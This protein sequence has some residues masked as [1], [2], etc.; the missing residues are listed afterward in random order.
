MTPELGE[1]LAWIEDL[2]AAGRA[3]S[4]GLVGNVADVHEA[5]L[6]RRFQPDVVTDQCTVDPYRG[7][8][9]SGLMPEAMAALVRSDP[10][11]ALRRAG[12]TLRR[13]ARALLEF[14]DRGALVFE[15]GNTLRMRAA[16]AGVREALE[17]DSFVTLFIRPLFCEGIGPFR[18][19]AASGAPQDIDA[20]DALIAELFEPG[21]R[22]R[23]WIELARE[24]VRFQGLPARI[25]WLGH[26]ERSRLALA[27]N[28]AVADRRI[29]APVA[30]TRD[31]L[32]AGSVASPFRE[33]EKMKD[34]SDPI[35]DWPILN[36]LLAC[37]NGADL[38]ALHAN[39]GRMMSA[40]Q[41]AV[42]DGSAAAAERL[43]AVLDAD[44]GLGIARYADAGY[45]A[46][47]AAAERHGIG[48]SL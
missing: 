10:V 32:D 31:H 24:H 22:I 7:Y 13:H 34:G 25:G 37:A 28:A 38:V 12:D 15:Y 23:R 1:A 17:L 33:T 20:I 39:G 11:E 48:L 30:F 6:E 9:T 29:Q 40:G 46:A 26:G 27:V 21:H 3:G 47:L 8:V 42:A 45:D 2:R 16:D 4:V 41:T 36:A 19:I 43:R 44:T 5:L 35:A 14:R 18:W